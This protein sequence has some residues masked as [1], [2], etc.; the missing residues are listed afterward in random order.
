MQSTYQQINAVLPQCEFS[1]LRFYGNTDMS[2]LMLPFSV[3][4]R[5]T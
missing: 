5:T 1:L 3:I 2:L 4:K